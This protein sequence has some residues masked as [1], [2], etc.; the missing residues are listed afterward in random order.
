MQLLTVLKNL[1]DS[2]PGGLQEM[3]MTHPL[4]S[5]RIENASDILRNDSAYGKFSPTGTDPNQ[6]R[7]QK[8]HKILLATV[9]DL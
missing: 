2:E 4:T 5:K 7:F 9:A 1:S 8:M 3:F 6:A